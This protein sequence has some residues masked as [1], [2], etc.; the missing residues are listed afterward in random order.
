MEYR[1][2]KQLAVPLAVL[3]AALGL[4]WLNIRICPVYFLFH[5]PC[6]G[7]GLTRAMLALAQGN[8]RLSLQYNP[9]FIPLL[10]FGLAFLFSSR[11]RSFL[12][13]HEKTAIVTAV[14]LTVLLEVHNLQNPLLY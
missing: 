4:A 2:L 7:C 9:A 12:K 10:L 11:F 8:L 6:P 3:L 13:R 14:I 5:V 1:L